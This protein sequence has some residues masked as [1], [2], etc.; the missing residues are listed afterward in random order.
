MSN[1]FATAAAFQQ[2]EPSRRLT[3][4]YAPALKAQPAIRRV[5][6][7][8]DLTDCVELAFGALVMAGALLF[9]AALLRFCWVDGHTGAGL[10][11]AVRS[12]YAVAGVA[13]GVAIYAVGLGI[14]RLVRG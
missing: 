9:A 5:A 6:R 4:V 3:L 13:G 7:K 2:S 1:E 10:Q 12:V 8:A 14:H 11:F